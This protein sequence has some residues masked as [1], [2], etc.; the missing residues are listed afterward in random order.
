DLEQA[1]TVL[2]PDWPDFPG[3]VTRGAALALQAKTFLYRQQW[4]AALASAELV[5]NSGMYDLSVPYNE[6]FTEDQENS[7]E[8]VFEI[9]AMY[10]QGQTRSEEHTSEL[11]SRENLVCRLLLEKKKKHNW[12]KSLNEI[13]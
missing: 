13:R 6:I 5:I 2:P 8:S 11:Q 12:S 9:Q 1:V 3:R 7:R 4:A 10:R